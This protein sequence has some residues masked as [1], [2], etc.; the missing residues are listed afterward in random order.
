[1]ESSESAMR[2]RLADLPPELK[3]LATLADS[4]LDSTAELSEDGVLNIGRVPSKGTH[5]FRMAVYP[6]CSSFLLEHPFTGFKKDIPQTYQRVLL[7]MNGLHS[8]WL[9]LYS[10]I[11]MPSA[12]WQLDVANNPRGGW[13]G[14]YNKSVQTMLHFG[15][16]FEGDDDHVGYFMEADGRVHAYLESSSKHLHSWP[17]F[18]SF[19]AQELAREPHESTFDFAEEVDDQPDPEPPARI[20]GDLAQRLWRECPRIAAKALELQ[21][22]CIRLNTRRTEDAAIAVG[23]SKMGGAA[24]LPEGMPWP[25]RPNGRPLHLIGQLN[26]A[27]IGAST[28]EPMLPEAGLLSFFY[29]ADDAPNELEPADA[30]G[31]RVVFSPPRAPLRRL[32]EPKGLVSL[33]RP[34]SIEAIPGISLPDIW[35]VASK[36]LFGTPEKQADAYERIRDSL[37]EGA[38]GLHQL[39]GH[40][41]PVQHPVCEETVQLVT[42]CCVNGKFNRKRWKAVESQVAEWMLL[43]QVDSDSDMDVMWGDSGAIYFTIRRDDLRAGVFDRVW[44]VFQCY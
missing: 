21:Q 32:A 4:L 43:L 25:Q 38:G 20:E 41:S 9:S 7:A 2:R 12:T 26:L 24:D 3:P 17:D 42:G 16:R 28:V 22:P 27:D 40:D 31:W 37:R 33:L 5:A 34:C 44:T 15:S 11:G 35:Q 18:A 8:D 23:A 13:I 29:D 10:I 1:V 36:G 19:L 30:G 14:D 6:P 39:L